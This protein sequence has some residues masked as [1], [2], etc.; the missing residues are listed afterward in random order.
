MFRRWKTHVYTS[1]AILLIIYLTHH[2]KYSHQTNNGNPDYSIKLDLLPE[3][4]MRFE[5]YRKPKMNTRHLR[6]LKILKMGKFG[7]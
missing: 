2:Y 4:L 7:K 1:Y 5:K 6:I 3:Q